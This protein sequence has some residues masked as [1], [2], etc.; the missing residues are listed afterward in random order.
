MFNGFRWYDWVIGYFTFGLW[1]LWKMH[2]NGVPIFKVIGGF[3]V[4]IGLLFGG[5]TIYAQTDS[6]MAHDLQAAYLKDNLS[7]A[8]RIL[9]E[10]PN[11]TTKEG[12]TASEVVE[13]IKS[14]LKAEKEKIAQ[15][16]IK[17]KQKATQQLALAKSNGYDSYEAYEK[18]EAVKIA[19][20]KAEQ[21][22]A[23]REKAEADRLAKLTEKMDYNDLNRLFKRSSKYIGKHIVVKPPN[24]TLSFS[25]TKTS[26]GEDFANIAYVK[27]VGT[28]WGE[29]T[30]LNNSNVVLPNDIYNK[31]MDYGWDT[32]KRELTM[33]SLL[34]VKKAKF[35][36]TDN[37]SFDKTF[38][39]SA[40]YISGG[41][42]ETIILY[43]LELNDGTKFTTQ[44]VRF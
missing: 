33:Q 39:S 36:V 8:E 29:I 30:L 17:A 7:S 4:V 6:G 3:I 1:I 18:G 37:N 19:K 28:N 22:N 43:Y 24:H 12:L 34:Y 44:Q 15:E 23:K 11:I 9:K 5:L 32:L 21:E 13:K 10:N 2:K 38:G 31:L 27:S 26:V 40:A 42:D 20:E 25:F 16:K 35:Y 14:N 41:G